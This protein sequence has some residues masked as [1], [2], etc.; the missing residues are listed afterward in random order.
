MS[1]MQIFVKFAE[2]FSLKL[3]DHFTWNPTKNH[4][5]IKRFQKF[6][7]ESSAGQKKK[8]FARRFRSSWGEIVCFCISPEVFLGT[9]KRHFSEK[10]QKVSVQKLN[11]IR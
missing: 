11:V 4:K 1:Q 8:Q 7:L 10:W 9:L 3:H 5:Q 6:F 2:T